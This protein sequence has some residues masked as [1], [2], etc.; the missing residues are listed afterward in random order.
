[1]PPSPAVPFAVV[2][3]A[4]PAALM[5]ANAVAALPGRSAARTQPALVLRTE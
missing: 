3:L 5:L 1:M 4:I 2:A